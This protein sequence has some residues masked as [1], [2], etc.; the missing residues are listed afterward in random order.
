MKRIVIGS[1]VGAKFSPGFGALHQLK[2]PR[3][4]LRIPAPYTLAGGAVLAVATLAAGGH[5]H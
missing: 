1:E 5:L 3:L 4:R 2:R